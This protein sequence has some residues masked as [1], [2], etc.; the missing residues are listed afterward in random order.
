VKDV[1]RKSARAVFLQSPDRSGGA[2]SDLQSCLGQDRA[3]GLDSELLAV[4]D[5]VT[6]GVDERDYLLCWRSSLT[7]VCAFR[8]PTIR[9]CA[10]EPDAVDLAVPIE[11]TFDQP[12]DYRYLHMLEVRPDRTSVLLHNRQGQSDQAHRDS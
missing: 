12:H 5:L 7:L 8:A 9:R 1:V 2:R 4:D 11:E 6:M 10:L 3:D